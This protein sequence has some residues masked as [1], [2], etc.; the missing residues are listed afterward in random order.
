MWYCYS[1][2]HT[3]SLFCMNQLHALPST[4]NCRLQNAS[5]WSVVC[6]HALLMRNS[7]FCSAAEVCDHRQLQVLVLTLGWSPRQPRSNMWW[8]CSTN[9]SSGCANYSSNPLSSEQ[10]YKSIESHFLQR[11]L[12]PHMIFPS[13]T[14]IVELPLCTLSNFSHCVNKGRKEFRGQRGAELGMG[15]E[16]LRVLC[17]GMV[18]SG[19]RAEVGGSPK[20]S[21]DVVPIHMGSCTISRLHPALRASFSSLR[22]QLRVPSPCPDTTRGPENWRPSED[23]EQRFYPFSFEVW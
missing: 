17:Q 13:P 1:K 4:N 8:L 21:Q 14:T 20:H 11:Q 2:V 22:F 3:S 23:P 7:Q 15:A 12:F 18:G 5:K 16:K 6:T 19:N 9:K 10:I